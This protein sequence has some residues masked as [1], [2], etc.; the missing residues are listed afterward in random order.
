MAAFHL[1]L[2]DFKQSG[3][4]NIEG[5]F[6]EVDPDYAKSLIFSL[7]SNLSQLKQ[8]ANNLKN[9]TWRDTIQSSMQT[10]R[11]P[12]KVLD[13]RKTPIPVKAQKGKTPV[14]AK[15]AKNKE[16]EMEF[17]FPC[18]GRGIDPSPD[19]GGYMKNTN[20]SNSF[21][22]LKKV[23]YERNYEKFLL[24]K[25]AKGK[26]PSENRPLM[27]EEPE[28]I[29][30]LR[31]EFLR[32]TRRTESLLVK[33]VLADELGK[34]PEL[35]ELFGVVP[36]ISLALVQEVVDNIGQGESITIDEFLQ[37][38]QV[39]K[40]NLLKSRQ[41]FC[42]NFEENQGNPEKS[43]SLELKL[44]YLLDKFVFE[45]KEE[46][47]KDGF[48]LALQSTLQEN[49]LE[50]LQMPPV[51]YES[52][53]AFIEELSST[54]V[55]LSYDY[56]LSLFEVPE[57]LDYILPEEILQ[58]FQI[59]FNSL[60]SDDSSGVNA[61]LLISELLE[62][63]T[64]QNNLEV[65]ARSPQG[66][67]SIP[68]ETL[69]NL[70]KR[71]AEESP[72]WLTWEEFLRYF[73]I[74]GRPVEEIPVVQTENKPPLG[75]RYKITVPAPFSFT[76]RE[77]IK[78]PS[79]RERKVKEMMEKDA[80]KIDKELKNQFKAQPVPP[81]VKIPMFQQIMKEQEDRRLQ[82]KTRFEAITKSL[83][84]PFSFY[85]RDMAKPEIKPEEAKTMVFHADPVPWFCKVMLCEKLAKQEDLRKDRILKMAKEALNHSKMPPRMEMAAKKIVEVKKAKSHK[86]KGFKAKEVPDFKTMHA[87]F[88]E[89]LSAVK[90]SFTPTQPNPFKFHEVQRSQDSL[91][92]LDFHSQA[93]QQWAKPDVKKRACSAFTKPKITPGITQKTK[94]MMLAKQ[95]HQEKHK[96][97]EQKK[98]EEN[99]IR[100]VKHEAMRRL[101][102]KSAVL[103]KHHADDERVQRA[104]A[105]KEELHR[106]EI[107]YKVKL[108]EIREKVSQRPL[109]VEQIASTSMSKNFENMN[110]VRRLMQQ[111]YISEALTSQEQ[112]ISNESF[113]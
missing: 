43:L 32:M 13:Y 2:S 72:E 60:K 36:P 99:L 61:N 33:T 10:F 50:I 29:Q 87:N 17:E 85:Y 48:I 107:E 41:V 105:R 112:E 88:S 14:E 45:S 39:S 96:E 16:K 63:P 66:L 35:G 76:R 110:P 6:T 104:N 54:A 109:L 51:L 15:S 11:T 49:I 56:L 111:E 4:E 26:C 77:Q 98:V 92:L 80:A 91:K 12:A 53:E 75:F 106:A 69:E 86:G 90:G 52:L 84:K 95:E 58:E 68:E 67:P 46:A 24:Q 71:L 8:E 103:S 37:F 5:N 34:N 28:I 81:E 64:I 94:D 19:L 74:E 40:N 42:E 57:V 21:A 9:M 100:K 18:Y 23:I 82:L 89:C 97:K 44:E 101:M 78:Q 1:S 70:L 22:P 108:Q 30:Y 62:N 55:P 79:I 59:V 3:T 65:L 7:Q 83:E 38:Y 47:S 20:V 93:L 31:E 102:Q 27:W 113:G 25:Y 73:S